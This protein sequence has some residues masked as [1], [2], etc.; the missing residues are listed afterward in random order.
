MLVLHGCWSRGGTWRFA[1]VQFDEP[2]CIQV[3]TTNGFIMIR[4]RRRFFAVNLN[5]DSSGD[6]EVRWMP[7]RQDV[8][9]LCTHIYTN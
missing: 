1:D 2:N 4:L 7:L 8:V 9:L 3:L 6:V 5:L